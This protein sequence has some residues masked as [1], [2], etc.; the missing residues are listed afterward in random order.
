M[1]SGLASSNMAV[2]A[3]GRR[4]KIKATV[5]PKTGYQPLFPSRAPVW[6]SFGRA[7]GGYDPWWW[8]GPRLVHVH[9]LSVAL[10]AI[11][12]SEQEHA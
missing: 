10:M 6:G 1:S 5:P 4:P 2:G 11:F 12:G 8:A 7:G 3:Q 9:E